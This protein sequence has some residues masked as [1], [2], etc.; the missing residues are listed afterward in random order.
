MMIDLA[1]CDIGWQTLKTRTTTR[2]VHVQFS[3]CAGTSKSTICETRESENFCLVQ[4][5][6]H[7]ADFGGSAGVP[8]AMAS[9]TDAWAPTRVK[10][11]PAMDIGR[12]DS[13]HFFG[14]CCSA[15]TRPIYWCSGI[16]CSD[17]RDLCKHCIQISPDHSTA[18]A[19]VETGI[20]K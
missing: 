17:I 6:D 7:R 5:R 18:P 9:A 2:A 20:Q 12:S 14:R 19:V 15:S 10:L 1:N 4:A 16:L 11:F 13:Q 3:T 8:T